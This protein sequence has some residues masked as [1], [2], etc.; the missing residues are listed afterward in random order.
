MKPPVPSCA[1]AELYRSRTAEQSRQPQADPRR[2]LRARV[3]ASAA[4]GQRHWKKSQG[5]P[6]PCLGLSQR[7]GFRRGKVGDFPGKAGGGARPGTEGQHPRGRCK[8]GVSA[9]SCR[10]ATGGLGFGEG[11]RQQGVWPG[12]SPPPR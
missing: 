9:G 12:S 7:R 2:W 11:S 5:S 10:L 4:G 8:W 6:S 1:E 3:S